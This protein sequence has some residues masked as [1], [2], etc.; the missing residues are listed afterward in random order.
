MPVSKCTCHS[1]QSSAPVRRPAVQKPSTP[2][3]EDAPSVGPLDLYV[4]FAI[5]AVEEF[6]E[7]QIRRQTDDETQ[8]LLEAVSLGASVALRAAQVDHSWAQSYDAATA[9][10]R[11]PEK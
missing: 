4:T 5:T 3:W 10:L 9:H 7:R 1:C 8:L 11:Q 6:F 2:L